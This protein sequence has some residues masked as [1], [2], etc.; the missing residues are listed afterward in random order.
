MPLPIT[1]INN[2]VGEVRV[3]D[4]G[5]TLASGVGTSVDITG[6]YLPSELRQSDNL[7]TFVVASGAVS[8]SGSEGILSISDSIRFF[9][10]SLVAEEIFTTAGTDL[11]AITEVISGD[12]IVVTSGGDVN[13]PVFT[14]TTGPGV[15]TDAIVGVGDI[16]VTSGTNTIT[17][18][19]GSTT[20]GIGDVTGD[21]INAEF[22]SGGATSN[23]WLSI[24]T[25]DHASNKIPF[26]M[27]YPA[28]ITG[29]SYS[30]SL[31]ATDTDIEIHKSLAGAGTASTLE[32][33]WELRDARIARKSDFSIDEITIEAGDKLSLFAQRVTPGRN[34]KDVIVSL[35]IELLGGTSEESIEDYSGDFS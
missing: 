10:G 5:I 19:G 13:N 8:I 32:F 11:R 35:Y 15:I 20:S 24:S 25:K 28:R 16:T 27:L 29:I 7:E 30:N 21:L 4:L 17:I 2:T 9:A 6:L 3:D 26:V 22:T 12:N 14:V 31:D 34:P 1:L 18:S 33:T 23:V